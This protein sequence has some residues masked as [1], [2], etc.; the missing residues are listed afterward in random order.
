MFKKLISG[1]KNFIADDPEDMEPE[2]L[3][4]LAL[5]GSADES[6]RRDAARCLGNLSDTISEM[7]ASEEVKTA[8]SERIFARLGGVLGS[9]APAWL[10]EGA[11]KGMNEIANIQRYDMKPETLEAAVDPLIA[12]LGPNHGDDLR[13]AA[14]SA[15]GSIDQQ[16]SEDAAERAVQAIMNLVRREQASLRAELIFSLGTFDSERTASLWSE[17]AEYLDDPHPEV[18]GNSAAALWMIGNESPD[19]AV[20][21][22]LVDMLHSE[23][24][25]DLRDNVVNAL[26][27]LGRGV[28]SVVPALIEALGRDD[29]RHMS[30]FALSELGEEADA[31]V[32]ALA[33]L[34]DDEDHEESAVMALQ[35]IGTDAAREAL[36]AAGH[37]E[38]M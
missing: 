19:P 11:I 9:D 34:L 8:V 36:R 16:V 35:G 5:D 3:V 6:R 20:V 2:P 32:P 23:S 15:L 18:R 28:P 10:V 29:T 38:E 7:A 21:G 12:C 1:L 30:I 33:R 24:D 17:V 13:S 26:G 4:E 27:H 22:R 25:E 14:A 31:A 37:P